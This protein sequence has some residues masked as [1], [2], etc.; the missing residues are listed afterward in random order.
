MDAL[1]EL[2]LALVVGWSIWLVGGLALMAWFRRRSAPRRPSA[3]A[4]PPSRLA[5]PVQRPAVR[6]PAAS[7]RRDAFSELQTLLDEG[8]GDR[9]VG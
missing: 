7:P 8:T 5:S 6:P 1:N 2:P 4:V 3:K 9:R